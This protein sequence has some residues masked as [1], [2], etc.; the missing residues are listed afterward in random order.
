VLLIVGNR[1]RHHVLLN[2]VLSPG[3]ERVILPPKPF[4]ADGTVQY[5]AVRRGITYLV[6]CRVPP[7]PP[8]PWE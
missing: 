5:F 1:W 3:Y 8:S 2:G 6:T 7:L 4:A